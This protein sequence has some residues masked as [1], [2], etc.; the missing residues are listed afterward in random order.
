MG[1][2][3][4]DK[5]PSCPDGNCDKD[6][7]DPRSTGQGQYSDGCTQCGEVAPIAAGTE[8]DGYECLGCW[9]KHGTLKGGGTTG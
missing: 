1:S 3:V 2:M 5:D 4:D 7:K 6:G 9:E 8:E